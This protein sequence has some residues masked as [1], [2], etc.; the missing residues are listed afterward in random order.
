MDI[1]ETRAKLAEL[2]VAAGYTQQAVGTALGMSTSKVLRMESGSQGIQPRD[3]QA[4]L[5]LYGAADEAL[6]TEMMEAVQALRDARSQAASERHTGKPGSAHLRQKNIRPAP[7]HAELLRD[8]CRYVTGILQ[9]IHTLNEHAMANDQ[10][11]VAEA[12][13]ATMSA[14]RRGQA[15]HR[16]LQ[17][18]PPREEGGS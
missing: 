14:A 13:N 6:T 3:L 15:I 10:S 8:V 5:T 17:A 11:Q 18:T 4:M 1:G 16:R 9:A 7:E 12:V 2:R